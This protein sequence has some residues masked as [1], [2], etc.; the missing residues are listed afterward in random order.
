MSDREFFLA[1]V[2]FRPKAMDIIRTLDEGDDLDLVPEPDN[3][4]D[5]NAIA[6]Y[7]GED[8]IGYVPKIFS[9]ELSAAMEVSEY[10]CRVVSLNKNG[11]PWEACKVVVRPV[12]VEDVE[13]CY[14]EEGACPMCGEPEDDCS[15]EKED[16]G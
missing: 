5:S 2:K 15:C 14:L 7:C 1:G 8:H 6:V 10:E 16:E 13:E 3:K 12:I 9:S 4:F 11:A